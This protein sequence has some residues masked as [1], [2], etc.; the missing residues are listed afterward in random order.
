[1]AGTEEVLGVG[2]APPAPPVR[3]TRL[4]SLLQVILAEQQS[5]AA[6]IARLQARRAAEGSPKSYQTNTDC[7]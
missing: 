5:Q 3:R 2:T 6:A 4:E 7:C 1:M